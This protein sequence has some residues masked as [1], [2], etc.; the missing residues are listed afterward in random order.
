[1]T[2][3]EVRTPPS[4]P[5]P[6][7]SCSLRPAA[8]YS[9]RTPPPSVVASPNLAV[10]GQ[11]QLPGC[12]LALNHSFRHPVNGERPEIAGSSASKR[13]VANPAGREQREGRGEGGR[14]CI[15]PKPGVFASR[16]GA[17]RGERAPSLLSHP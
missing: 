16:N 5:S 10:L 7:V 17:A 12:N 2:V 9:S 4:R 14:A 1:M 11:G 3:V 8:R 15:P 6:V 13:K